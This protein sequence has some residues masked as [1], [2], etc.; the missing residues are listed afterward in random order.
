V[1]GEDLIERFSVALDKAREI[2]ETKETHPVDLGC[3]ICGFE[4]QLAPVEFGVV[5]AV[6][7]RR[8]RAFVRLF[9]GLGARVG[10]GALQE[11]EDFAAIFL[12]PVHGVVAP[13]FC[14]EFCKVLEVDDRSGQVAQRSRVH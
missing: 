7:R 11:T 4:A 13:A 9:H 6:R 10:H 12:F 1:D 8:I 2:E 14:E 3:R 5:V